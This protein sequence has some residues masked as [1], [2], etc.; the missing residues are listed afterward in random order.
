[1][2][3][4]TVWISYALR[5]HILFSYLFCV[6]IKQL[7]ICINTYVIFMKDMYV[8]WK[9][10]CL[11]NSWNDNVPLVTWIVNERVRPLLTI[12][13]Y[14]R[15]SNIDSTGNYEW[16][17][18]SLREHT[19][20]PCFPGSLNYR[21]FAF[22]KIKLL[23][24]EIAHRGSPQGSLNKFAWNERV[25]VNTDRDFPL[26]RYDDVSSCARV[27]NKGG[28]TISF[29]RSNSTRYTSTWDVFENRCRNSRNRLV[30]D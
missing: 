20:R 21:M 16:F 13:H 8:E 3:A 6:T 24:V 12:Q 26:V 5:K 4:L 25:R 28:F 30:R 2:L 9:L 1:M 23:P 11:I 7:Y 22:L 15:C 29:C 10:Q 27:L 18:T 19:L 14:K 17:F